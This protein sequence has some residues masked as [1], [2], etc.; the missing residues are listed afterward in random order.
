[1]TI[2]LEDLSSEEL[3]KIA[4][5]L[6]ESYTDEQMNVNTNPVL[7]EVEN[8]LFSMVYAANTAFSDEVKDSITPGERIQ[9]LR[10]CVVMA[11]YLGRESMAEEIK[12]AALK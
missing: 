5:D 12:I 3:I 1:M 7:K 4:M 10:D 8:E 11:F 9:I 6:R 2:K